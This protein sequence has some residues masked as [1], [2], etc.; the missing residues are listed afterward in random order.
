MP[1]A[2]ADYLSMASGGAKNRGELEYELGAA[3]EDEL[4]AARAQGSM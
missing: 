2:G 1:I 3:G 4:M